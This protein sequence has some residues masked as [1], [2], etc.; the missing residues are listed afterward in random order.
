MAN[1]SRVDIP[2]PPSLI[3][4]PDDYARAYQDS[5][6]NVLRLYF[7][8]LTSVLR[9][10]FGV[11][12]GAI[13]RFPHIAASDLTDQ[14]AGG[15]NTP[16]L[17]LWDTLDSSE[18]FTLNPSGSATASQQGIYKIDYSL[19][20]VNTDN[21]QED[22]YVWLKVNGSN[23]PGSASKFTVPARKSAGIFGYLIAYSSITFTMNPEDDMELWWQTSKAYNPVGPVN[24]V[25]M[26][27]IPAGG[28]LP[29]APSAVGTIAFISAIA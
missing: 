12:G 17:V 9:A 1:L 29:S 19:Q 11:S 25:Y 15:N 21:A 2:A 3:N 5:Y 8:R 13:L 26:E 24:G 16:T 20:F 7:T 10:L 14:Y 18:G 6:S 23:V 4:A 28:A 22:L 27:Y